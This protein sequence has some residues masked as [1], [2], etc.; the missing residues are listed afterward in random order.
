MTRS[1]LFV[2]VLALGGCGRQTVTEPDPSEPVDHVESVVAGRVTDIEGSP[3][4]FA[5]VWVCISPSDPGCL[6]GT[7]KYTDSDGRFLI[8]FELPIQQTYPVRATVEATPPVGQGYI[9][10]RVEIED[11]AGVFEPPPVADTTFVDIV[12]PPNTVDSRR[13]I[14]VEYGLHRSGG[15]RADAN[16]FYLSTPSGVVAFDPVTGEAFWQR[17]GLG[18]L[19][20]PAYTL[21]GDL[22]VVA[23]VE[24]LF[25]VRAMDG[26]PVWSREGVPNR[27]ITVADPD[28]LYATDGRGVVAYDPATGEIR[29]RNDLIGSGSVAL[30]ASGSLVCAEILAYVECWDPSTGDP[31]WSRP[32]DFASWLAI[33]D[34]RVI[35]GS[36]AGWTALEAETGE[37]VWAAPLGRS[38]APVIS[39]AGDLAFS[40]AGSSCFA[41]RTSDGSLA[42]TT[43]FE[44]VPA[45]LVL[46]GESLFVLEGS[47]PG[48]SLQVLDAANGGIRERILPDP[49]D[50][51]FCPDMAVNDDYVAIRG[52]AT[53][54]VFERFP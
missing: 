49:F 14:R 8:R 28:G 6:I 44:E 53:L 16:R 42:W 48:S 50:R 15:L 23:G 38:P 25:A 4:E 13:P 21:Q 20:G 3:V 12:L 19:A 1:R 10:G 31:V 33:A 22:V 27:R 11:V 54:Y 5:V 43:S 39:G 36:E 40:C 45:D 29:W 2:L 9:L 41:I 17:G 7:S 47:G 30:A 34:D 24:S 52:C 46:D 37:I 26:A 32:T 35:V 51:G 18:G